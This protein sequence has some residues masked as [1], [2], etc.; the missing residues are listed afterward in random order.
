MKKIKTRIFIH[1]CGDERGDC[2]TFCKKIIF[3][4]LGIGLSLVGCPLVQ[5]QTP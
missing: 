5:K 3:L 4:R 1:M 2:V